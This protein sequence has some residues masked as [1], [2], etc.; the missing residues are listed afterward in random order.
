MISAVRST[1]FL[2]VTC[3]AA[4][5]P[6]CCWIMPGRAT[7]RRVMKTRRW[8]ASNTCGFETVTIVYS[9]EV[10]H[11]DSHGRGGVIGPGATFSGCTAGAGILHEEFHSDAFTRWG[12]ELKWCSCGLTFQ[13]CDKMTT[14]LKHYPRCY[15][16]RYVA[17][18]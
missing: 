14:G 1:L 16:D 7:L 12:G 18:G 8:G 2:S 13:W 11:R 15:P 17:A 5:V 4:G 10:E 3:A 6:P 9:G